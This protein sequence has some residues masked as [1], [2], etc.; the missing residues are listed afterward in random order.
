MKKVKYIILLVFLAGIFTIF[1]SCSSELDTL[2]TETN[3]STFQDLDETNEPGIFQMT[4]SHFDGTES[5]TFNVSMNDNVKFKYTSSNKIG[6][7]SIVVIDPYGST[8][9]NIPINKNGT[10]KV[11]AK[12]A[13]KIT[14]VVTSRNAT[15]SFKIT[16][17]K[18]LF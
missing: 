12:G 17:S 7:L 15:G 8:I 18:S 10:F 11:K 3:Q 6:S 13:G 9:A 1:T 4:Y 16:W 2:N 14:F 5:R